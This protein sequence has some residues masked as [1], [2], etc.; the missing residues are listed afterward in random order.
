MAETIFSK[1]IRK[2]IPADIVFEDEECLAFNDINPQ[3][4]THVLVIPKKPIREV[5]EMGDE[6]VPLIGHLVKVARD[7][8]AVLN[9][10][11]NQTLSRTVLTSATTFAA[12]GSLA[13]LGG[14]VIRPFAVAMLIGVVVGTYSSVYIAAPTLLFL[15]QR[16]GKV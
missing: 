14:D 4:P 13:L 11:V 3:A 15:E 16:Y 8:A 6:D 12:V 5:A 7:I 2:E 1:I 10:S 9:Q